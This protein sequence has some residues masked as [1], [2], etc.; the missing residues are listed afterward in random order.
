MTKVFITGNKA[1]GS[2]VDID[3]DVNDLLLEAA[4]G[5]TT[6]YNTTEVGIQDF[7]MDLVKDFSIYLTEN[8]DKY[9]KVLAA[10]FS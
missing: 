7:Y 8:E 1:S 3:G 5:F 4:T 2:K 10:Y 6:K 9:E